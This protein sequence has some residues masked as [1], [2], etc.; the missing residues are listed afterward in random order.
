MKAEQK[1]FSDI[2]KRSWKMYLL[3][4]NLMKQIPDITEQDIEKGKVKLTEMVEE[5][6][7]ILS[8]Y[9]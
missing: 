9:Y 4:R 2:M 6:E 1:R 7:D 3:S 8:K 5:L